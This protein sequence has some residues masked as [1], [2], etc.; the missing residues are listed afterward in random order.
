MGSGGMYSTLAD[1]LRFNHFVQSGEVLKNE[2]ASRMGGETVVIGGSE[3]GLYFSAQA[4]AAATP[5]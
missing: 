1:R 4:T 2:Y 5:R 3:R